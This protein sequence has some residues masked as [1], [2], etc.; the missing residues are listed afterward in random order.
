MHK[1]KQIHGKGTEIK[2]H[3]SFLNHNLILNNKSVSVILFTWFLNHK[4]NGIYVL[5]FQVFPFEPK[6]FCWYCIS[7]ILNVLKDNIPNLI[8]ST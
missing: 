6:W 2:N 7:F 5:Y 8:L 3:L 1:K 4:F